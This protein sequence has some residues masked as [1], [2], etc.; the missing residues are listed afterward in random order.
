M[1]QYGASRWARG[2]TYGNLNSVGTAWSVNWLDYRQM[3]AHYYT[4]IELR[5]SSGGF[6]FPAQ[7][8]NALNHTVPGMIQQAYSAQI[9]VQNT[10][11]Y[12]WDSYYYISYR[13]L[14]L[15]RSPVSEPYTAGRTS[16]PLSPGANGT[17]IV[18]VNPP[19]LNSP[20]P[21]ILR[22]DMVWV[23]PW[24][25]SGYWFS[26]YG[27]PTQEV[28]VC[29]GG[30]CN[31]FAPLV[32]KSAELMGPGSQT[33]MQIQN[34]GRANATITVRYYDMKT[35]AM[36]TY[37]PPSTVAPN[38]SITVLGTESSGWNPPVPSGF[39][40]SAVIESDQPILVIVNE[41]SDQGAA[42]QYRGSGP[43]LTTEVKIPSVKRGLGGKSTE[44]I[45]QNTGTA[46]TRV[47]VNYSGKI[48][49]T[50][51]TGT[52]WR[53]INPRQSW[54]FK[55]SDS[56]GQGFLGAATV[57]ASGQP[58]VA[59][60]N[61]LPDWGDPNYGKIAQSTN[62][63]ASTAATV[64]A[65]APTQKKSLYGKSTGLQAQNAGSGPASICVTW[66]Q[67]L[68]ASG[69]GTRY[70]H[71]INNVAVGDS[72][73]FFGSTMPTPSNFLGSAI[74]AGTQ[75]I[76]AIVNES[77]DS[78]SIPPTGQKATTY[79][80]INS[81]VPANRVY[82]PLQ[83]KS[84]DGNNTGI[85]VMNV[86]DSTAAVTIAY[87]WIYPSSGTCATTRSVAS[88]ASTTFLA[89]DN[90]DLACVPSGSYGSAVITAN[91]PIVAIVNESKDDGSQDTKNYEGFNQ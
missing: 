3:L 52:D 26:D 41:R 55:A 44:V 75:P 11:S 31:L 68:P 82:V 57:T 51:V 14:N 10:G 33:G 81:N 85:Q 73:T 34:I 19:T 64:T 49:E 79:S 9:R 87:V 58:I 18:T 67:Q 71:C 27:W 90:A 8:W 42:A 74:V 15:D 16:A 72:A 29:V 24:Y 62:G 88:L 48:G 25:P 7:R 80:A 61:D 86:G 69:A 37:T 91:Q 1:S 59:V 32:L 66:I 78:G 13:W 56:V 43:S 20:R 38:A 50:P 21:L 65:Y 63:F 77:Y 45:V 5:S 30:S 36:H 12:V 35:G 47:T 76:V 17:Y 83:K 2:N 39:I 6:L 4:Q 23:P 28:I 53:D 46:T 22:W 89:R 54:R 40:G 84:F 70:Q 60:Y